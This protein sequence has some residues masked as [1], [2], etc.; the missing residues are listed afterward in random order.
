MKDHKLTVWMGVLFAFVFAIW[1][2]SYFLIAWLFGK[3][4]SPGVGGDLFGAIGALFSGWAFVG[5]LWAILLQRKALQVQ[6]D[7]L[8]ATLD[9]MKQAREAHEE[10]ADTLKEQVEVQRLQVRAQ[11]LTGIVEGA[12]STRENPHLLGKTFNKMG[13]F[14]EDNFREILQELLDIN[15]SIKAAAEKAPS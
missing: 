10:S 12:I 9:E 11:I 14:K 13:V 5:V 15:A 6:H 3:P 8:K 1:L 7:D 4:D 2:G